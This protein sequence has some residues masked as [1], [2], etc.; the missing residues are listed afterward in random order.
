M[1]TETEIILEDRY[2]RERFSY[3]GGDLLFSFLSIL[4]QNVVR[5]LFVKHHMAPV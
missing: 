4:I 2:E 3:G 5:I 1:S